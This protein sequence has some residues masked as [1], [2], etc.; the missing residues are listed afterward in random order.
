MIAKIMNKKNTC[1]TKA[2]IK[3]LL[4]ASY[5]IALFWIIDQGMKYGWGL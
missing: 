2:L 3:V 4:I 5:L 1:Y